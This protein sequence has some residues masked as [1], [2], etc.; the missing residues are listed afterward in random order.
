M[1]ARRPAVSWT[2]TP[3]LCKWSTLSA[4]PDSNCRK[5]KSFFRHMLCAHQHH[6]H[7]FILTISP[8]RC[9][10]SARSEEAEPSLASDSGEICAHAGHAWR[11]P[12]PFRSPL[13]PAGGRADRTA[14]TAAAV[15]CSLR[16]KCIYYRNGSIQALISP[17][18]ADRHF[19]TR[20]SWC[21]TARRADWPRPTRPPAH[22][23]WWLFRPLQWIWSAAPS[24]TG[25]SRVQV[26]EQ[27]K[28]IS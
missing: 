6:E 23:E 28:V 12:C 14:T 1:T 20:T 3:R 24:P 19:P 16:S 27:D 4:P 15:A 13:D 21:C 17:S 10:S 18:S 22:S 2:R 7:V 8:Q 9:T 26:I 25:T 5:W 11:A